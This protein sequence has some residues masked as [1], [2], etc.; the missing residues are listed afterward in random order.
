MVGMDAADWDE[1]AVALE[2][3]MI[4]KVDRD[5]DF[6]LDV[7]GKKIPNPKLPGGG[8]DRV[9]GI[10]L[11]RRGERKHV[12]LW[13]NELGMWLGPPEGTGS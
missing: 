2:G 6:I 12:W 11:Q 4:V 9:L 3:W 13:F 8:V 7:S 10:H 5:P 1:I